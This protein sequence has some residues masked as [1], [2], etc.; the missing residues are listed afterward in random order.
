M[1]STE[2]QEP[3]HPS[4]SASA[5]SSSSPE[6]HSI[7]TWG[8]G[9]VCLPSARGSRPAALH[10]DSAGGGGAKVLWGGGLDGGRGGAAAPPAA[11]LSLGPKGPLCQTEGLCWG[12]SAS[13]EGVRHAQVPRGGPSPAL[14]LTRLSE[15]GTPFGV[16]CLALLTPV[17]PPPDSNRLPESSCY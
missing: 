16:L 6:S 2:G 11:P 14:S 8:S 15:D 9:L 4:T 10:Q 12:L 5:H 3:S 13:W 17:S 7:H 1:K